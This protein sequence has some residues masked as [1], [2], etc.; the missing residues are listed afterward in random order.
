MIIFLNIAQSDGLNNFFYKLDISYSNK[1]NN[2]LV[3]KVF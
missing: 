1:F 3:Y 2:L